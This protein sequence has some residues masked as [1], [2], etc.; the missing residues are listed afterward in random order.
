[1][2]AAKLVV[3]YPVP[4]DLEQFERR[5]LEHHVPMAVDRLAGK[6]KIVA[7]KV[8]SSAQ[9]GS[10]P[11]HRIAE[12][13]FPSMSALQACAASEGAQEAIAN[14]VSISTGGPPSFIVA[15]EGTSC[16]NVGPT[17]IEIQDRDVW[18]LLANTL[19]ADFLSANPPQ[20]RTLSLGMR[21]A[22]GQVADGDT[23]RPRASE[24]LDPPRSLC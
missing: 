3:I 13:H 16:S 19:Y 21:P 20:R 24:R 8:L 2:P 17:G 12:I 14:A 23:G 5:Y 18:L 10:A 11:F 1:M 22:L 15:E 4:T 6:T 7:T 9:G